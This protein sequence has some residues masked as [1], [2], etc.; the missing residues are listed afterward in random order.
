MRIWNT[1]SGH[2]I[3]Q[4]LNGR[5]NVFLLSD[6]G[7]NILI[8]TSPKFMWNRLQNRLSQLKI[9]KI[10]YLILTHTHFDHAANSRQLKI[11]YG[12][13][14]I[15]HRSEVEYLA[16]GE[17]VLLKGTNPVSEVIAWFF[18]NLFLS[19]AKYESCQYDLM[20]DS[21]FNLSDLGFNGYIIHTPGHSP[22]SMSVVID[23]EV[24]LV[25]DTMFGVF[26]CTI[27]PPFASDAA[28]MINSW[29][30]LLETNSTIFI[31]SHGFAN[32][33]SLV[34]K[35]FKRRSAAFIKTG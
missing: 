26:R 16:N 2:K 17:N 23:D 35:E 29:G 7:K 15:V 27:Y 6:K 31:P 32:Q 25:G 30:K 28:Q 18:G 22:G 5:S 14:V 8:D 21:T 34:E 10:D 11:K 24:A 20:V 19:L 9:D 4:V 1:T 12:A 33:R 3:V 13:K